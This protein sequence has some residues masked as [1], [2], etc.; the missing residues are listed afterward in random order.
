MV[1]Y[2]QVDGT[3]HAV[4][5]ENDISLM[6]TALNNSIPGIDGDCGGAAA[7]GTCHIYIDDAWIDKTGHACDGIEKDMLEFAEQSGETS[8]LACQ[9]KMTDELDGLIVRLPLAQH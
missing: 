9:V 3:R 5:A 8:R 2:V 6:E 4:Q 1:T 7:C